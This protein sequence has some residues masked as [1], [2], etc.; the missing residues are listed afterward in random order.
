[1]GERALRCTECAGRLVSPGS[2]GKCE[3]C[4]LLG[5][6]RDHLYSGRF[7]PQGAP[8]A[9]S[10]LREA[11]LRILETSESFWAFNERSVKKEEEPA[12]GVKP[13]EEEIKPEVIAADKKKP[14]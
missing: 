10:A 3:V 13:E 14:L 11:L 5:R 12:R 2:T 7:P 1:M 4:W 8:T 6:L 9:A